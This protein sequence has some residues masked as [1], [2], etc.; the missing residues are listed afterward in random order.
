MPIVHPIHVRAENVVDI[1]WHP[2]T[3]PVFVERRTCPL[4][5]TLDVG[6]DNEQ[7]ARLNMARDEAR[8]AG[9]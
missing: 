5:E 8:K 4:V 2:S 6:G 1:H 7:M 3:G 9:K